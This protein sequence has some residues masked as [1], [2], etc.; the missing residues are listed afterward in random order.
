[1]RQVYLPHRPWSLATK[2]TFIEFDKDA[3]PDADQIP[4]PVKKNN[5]KEVL[6][7]SS[8][9]GCDRLFGAVPGPVVRSRERALLKPLSVLGADG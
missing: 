8:T 7:A 1:L 2:G 9:R 4:D 3:D 6:D 5:S